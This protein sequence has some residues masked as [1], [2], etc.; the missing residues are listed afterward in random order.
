MFKY[1]VIFI[2]GLGQGMI[3]LDWYRD[4]QVLHLAVKRGNNGGKKAR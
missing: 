4:K 2:I 3:L 1:L